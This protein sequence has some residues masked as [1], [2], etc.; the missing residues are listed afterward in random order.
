MKSSCWLPTRGWISLDKVGRNSAPTWVGRNCME[1][2]VLIIS[3]LTSALASDV[4]EV[5][6]FVMV[7]YNI[8]VSLSMLL[9]QPM[10]TCILPES[11]FLCRR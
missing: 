6:A 4:V 5:E 1:S 10:S 7:Y 8:V 2:S 11:E 3:S 9:I